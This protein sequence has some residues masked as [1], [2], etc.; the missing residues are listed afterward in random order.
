MILKRVK[1][2]DLYFKKFIQDKSGLFYFPESL[3]LIMNR[4]VQSNKI[5][6]SVVFLGE[7]VNGVISEDKDRTS[8][9]SATILVANNR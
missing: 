5:S 8:M 4:L 7:K 2:N 6:R 3:L 1:Y 9:L